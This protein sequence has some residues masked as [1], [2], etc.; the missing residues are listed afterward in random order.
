MTPKAHI[1]LL[2]ENKNSSPL[3]RVPFVFRQA[4]EFVI[5]KEFGTKSERRA[6]KVK[7][8]TKALVTTYVLGAILVFACFMRD[9]ISTYFGLRRD[10]A[11]QKDS[12]NL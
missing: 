4:L 7:R 1:G 3:K 12:K 6:E 10:P 9:S 11:Y 2:K 8:L 5:S